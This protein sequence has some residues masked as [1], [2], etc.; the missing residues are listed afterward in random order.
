MKVLRTNR[1]LAR[2][3][4]RV[5][6]YKLS[7]TNMRNRNSNPSPIHMALIKE[8]LPFL[9]VQELLLQSFSKPTS[10]SGT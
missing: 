1:N 6:Y 2:A 8:F 3:K 7:H 9:Q 4:G 10:S 5:K